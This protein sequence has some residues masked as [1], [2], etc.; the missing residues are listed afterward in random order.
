[1]KLLFIIALFL[2]SCATNYHSRGMMGTGYNDFRLG[3]DRFTI[4]LRGNQYTT[5]EDVRKYA[6][7][8]ASELTLRH[9]Y[10]Y[11]AVAE[12]KDISK[13]TEVHAPSK[14]VELINPGIEMTIQ[15]FVEKPTIFFIDAEEFIQ[16]NS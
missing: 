15:C 7:Q 11:F 16:F 4:T 6:L 5:S 3:S 10:L 14:N 8:R 1:M 12:E 2:A 13:K 9:G